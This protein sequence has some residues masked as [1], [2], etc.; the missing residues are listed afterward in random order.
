MVHNLV[1]LPYHET[2]GYTRAVTRILPLRNAKFV[3]SKIVLYRIQVA[4]NE[5]EENKKGRNMQ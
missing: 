2:A 1:E 4:T 3:I 5:E